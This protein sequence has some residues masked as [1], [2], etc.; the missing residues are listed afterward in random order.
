MKV[1]YFF[2]LISSFKI[3]TTSY[4]PSSLYE[5]YQINIKSNADKSQNDT[6]PYIFLDPDGNITNKDPLIQI[7]DQIYRSKKINTIIIII[8]ELDSSISSLNSF[9]SNFVSLFFNYNND[10][11]DKSLTITIS[12][13]NKTISILIGEE[14]KKIFTNKIIN[15]IQNNINSELNKENYREVILLI[16]NS[17]LSAKNKNSYVA[18][19]II[20]IVLVIVIIFAIFLIYNLYMYGVCCNCCYKKEQQSSFDQAYNTKL[21]NFL[22][23]IKNNSKNIY[24]EFCIL[25]LEKLEGNNVNKKSNDN[26]GSSELQ[27]I[28]VN[29]KK[30]NNYIDKLN[31]IQ[32][33]IENNDKNIAN[34]KLHIIDNNINNNY[35]KSPEAINFVDIKYIND[36]IIL[37]CNHKFHQSCFNIYC[38]TQ[39]CPLCLEQID[40]SNDY[41]EI[42]QKILNVQKKIH[43]IK[44]I[45]IVNKVSVQYITPVIIPRRDLYDDVI[46]GAICWIICGRFILIFIHNLCHICC[47]ICCSLCKLK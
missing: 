42:R 28:K 23:T 3:I 24:K 14:T 4:S 47:Y 9:S 44:G 26:M 20:I 21:E 36:V 43:P 15:K 29:V 33:P 41:K 13:L 38:A 22:N 25:C 27:A 12:T 1:K 6:F 11:I 35:N 18:I 46:T 5:Y 37:S 30:E 34:N 31:D 32:K 39:P 2:F 16:L 17:C 40:S 7:Q 8:D 45:F 19:I 10:Y